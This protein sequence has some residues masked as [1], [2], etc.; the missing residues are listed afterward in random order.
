MYQVTHDS[1]LA[2]QLES[3]SI[4]A[5]EFTHAAHV[6]TAWLYLTD[7]G[8]GAAAFRS[9]LL[10]FVE[11]HGARDKYHETMTVAYLRIIAARLRAHEPWDRFAARNQ[12]LL[13]RPS[14][15]LSVHYSEELLA[16]DEARRLF[17]PADRKSLPKPRGATP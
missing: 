6:E 10:R 7:P 12:D 14:E 11:H 5:G 3:L 13:Q 9:A 17:L 4:P 2:D 16:S 15:V 1:S 8:R